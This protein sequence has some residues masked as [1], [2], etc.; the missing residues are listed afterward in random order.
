MLG[1]FYAG[2]KSLYFGTALRSRFIYMYVSVVELGE[3]VNVTVCK[4]Y[5]MRHAI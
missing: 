4:L 5:E 3:Y 2:Y 1:K